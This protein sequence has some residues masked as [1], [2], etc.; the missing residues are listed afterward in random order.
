[1]SECKAKAIQTNLGTF[2][3]NQAHPGI[4]QV[5]SGIFRTLCYPDIF[6]NCGISRT[7]TYSEPEAYS[8][9]RYIQNVGKFKIWGIFI[10]LSCIYDEVF[11]IFTAIIIFTNY[12]YFRNKYLEE[13]S[14]EVVILYKKLLLARGPGGS[15]SRG[16][17]AM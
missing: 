15:F 2:R 9:P 14:P 11:I 13:V 1:M 5:Y 4:I 6:Y 10:T 8:E 16:S 7:L 12:N 3:R 17:Y